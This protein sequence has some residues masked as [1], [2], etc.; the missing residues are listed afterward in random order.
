M[1][2]GNII[3]FTTEL[4]TKKK[5]SLNVPYFDNKQSTRG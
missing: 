4:P 1:D 3:N 5:N 2:K